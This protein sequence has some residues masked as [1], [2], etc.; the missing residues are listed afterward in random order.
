MDAFYVV[1]LGIGFHRNLP[2]TV[3]YKC[4]SSGESNFIKLKFGPFIGDWAQIVQQA[5]AVFVKVH[6]NEVAELFAADRNQA[7]AR[8]IKVIEVLRVPN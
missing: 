1:N 7:A 4:M 8:K 6:K 3:E 5:D 2:I